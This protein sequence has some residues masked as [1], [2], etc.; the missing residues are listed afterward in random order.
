MGAYTEM[1]SLVKA[2]KI[3]EEQL[4]RRVPF[5]LLIMDLQSP[6]NPLVLKLAKHAGIGSSALTLITAQG[7][8]I[9]E[10]MSLLRFFY[11]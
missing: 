9:R 6:Q 10:K 3:P 2:L 1:L 11:L 5:E 8:S 4:F 7:L